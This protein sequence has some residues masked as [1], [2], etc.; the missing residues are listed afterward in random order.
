M[1]ARGS[2]LKRLLVSKNVRRCSR[3][4]GEE[5]AEG[6][7]QIRCRIK[8]KCPLE[9]L[10]KAKMSSVLWT[11]FF[12]RKKKEEFPVIANHKINKTAPPHSP[13]NFHKKER[14]WPLVLHTNSTAQWHRLWSRRSHKKMI[15]VTFKNRYALAKA[16]PRYKPPFW[17][18]WLDY[19]LYARIACPKMPVR[20]LA[21]SSSSDETTCDRYFLFTLGG[22]SHWDQS[23]PHGVYWLKILALCNFENKNATINAKKE[24]FIVFLSLPLELMVQRS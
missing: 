10:L 24:P 15:G 14:V 2:V 23:L 16:E 13:K 22:I 18:H 17:L 4:K 19:L 7:M 12:L 5:R 9:I 21:Q 6:I 8:K 20:L 11:Y 1:T 3:R